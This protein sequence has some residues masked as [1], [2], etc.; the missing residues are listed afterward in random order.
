MDETGFDNVSAG[1]PTVGDGASP[2]SA[3][4]LGGAP[5]AT[6]AAT[7]DGSTAAPQV[8]QVPPD[9]T[10]LQGRETQ[11][12][13]QG[14]LEARK[15]FRELYDRYQ[16]LESQYGERDQVYQQVEQLGG[17]QLASQA[18]SL[19]S[20]LFQPQVDELGYPVTDPYT[21]LPVTSSGA[22]VQTIASQ[23]WDTALDMTEQLL[24]LPTQSGEP[25]LAEVVRRVL[26]LDPN[27]MDLYRQISSPADAAAMGLLDIQPIELEMIP[28][29]FHDTYRRLNPIQRQFVQD[30]NLSQAQ[31]Q[32]RLADYREQHRMQDM[33]QQAE[34]YQNQQRE[35]QAYQWAQQVEAQ[36]E[37]AAHVLWETHAGALMNDLDKIQ[38]STDPATDGHIKQ[39]IAGGVAVYVTDDPQVGQ[40][41]IQAYELAR[42][43][44]RL[45]ASG[46]H[47]Q[48][49]QAAIRAQQM[50]GQIAGKAQIYMNRTIQAL[51]GFSGSAQ[52]QNGANGATPR[53]MI[54]ANG[55]NQLGQG[56]SSKWNPA[57]GPKF[58]SPEYLNDLM[59]RG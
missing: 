10:D 13:A 22:F 12:Y 50:A 45:R 43:A 2:S 59:G 11:P 9:D 46:N 15:G 28:E 51:Q 23:N 27:K 25:L 1:T 37:Q 56:S 7:T 42:Q 40:M 29:E 20:Q 26:G 24:S 6:D 49:N 3:P 39:F 47:L 58:G 44:E 53:P 36:G 35:Y 33:I 19:V 54:S 30:E 4:T 32:Q 17:V 52:Q 57:T 5:G 14:L 21:G 38:W 34:A 16:G 48:A 31:Q 55:Q 8:F 41:R 18:V